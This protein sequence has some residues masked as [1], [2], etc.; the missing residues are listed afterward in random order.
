MH[1]YILN[2]V[3]NLQSAVDEK[4]AQEKEKQFQTMNKIYEAKGGNYGN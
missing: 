3:L 2:Q 4:K 1:L